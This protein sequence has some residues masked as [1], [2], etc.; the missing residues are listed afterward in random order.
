MG[1]TWAA[2]VHNMGTNWAV[3]EGTFLFPL[4][5]VLFCPHTLT[6]CRVWTIQPV[7]Q[8]NFIGNELF[9]VCPLLELFATFLCLG[10][11]KGSISEK[12]CSQ[13]KAT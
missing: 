11:E 8:Q 1:T 3:C 6:S 7:V 13:R 4:S 10:N 12:G 9:A 5:L 2:H